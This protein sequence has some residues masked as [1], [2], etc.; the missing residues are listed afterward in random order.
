MLVFLGRR[1]LQLIPLLLM[2]SFLSFAINQ[3]APGDPVMAFVPREMAQ[4]PEFLE[5]MRAQ[6]GLDKHWTIQYVR[7]LGKVVQ[8]DLGRSMITGQPV[9]DRFM[10]VV[11]NTLRLSL[12][13]FLL[14][15][16]VA[17][18]A[19][20][21]SAVRRHSWLDN[22]I[23][24]FTFAGVSIPAFFLGILLVLLFSLHLGWLPS[25]GMAPPGMSNPDFLTSVRYMV[26][27]VIAL[28]VPQIAQVAA[29]VRA[30]MLEVLRQDY[31]R[32]ANSKGLGQR[33]V[34]YKH[35]L[36]NALMPVITIVG[37]SLSGF[38]GGALVTENVFAWPGMGRVAV[39]AVF[40]KDYP[41][42]MAANLLFAVMTVIGNML[43]DIMYAVVDPRVK[44]S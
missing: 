33:V 14:S 9:L 34:I 2:I 40:Q 11:P 41:I 35:A 7:W 6:L 39:T 27:P 4:N 18:V 42:I 43:A 20:V 44:Y 29:F 28:T 37:L 19:G 36:R 30:S 15:F 32:T 21:V 23:V 8:G 5:N 38:V 22:I 13:A 10:Q 1:L 16:V 25:N 17:I 12:V 24:F 31:I 3:L 26:L